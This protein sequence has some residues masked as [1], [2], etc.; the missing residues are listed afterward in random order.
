MDKEKTS[1]SAAD[2][3]HQVL[4]RTEMI[5]WS[6]FERKR[7]VISMWPATPTGP[8]SPTAGK[9]SAEPASVRDGEPCWWFTE[10]F[11]N[12]RARTGKVLGMTC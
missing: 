1:E 9:T 5:D 8:P 4:G 12:Y 11:G 6:E 3:S 7:H 2:F 10:R